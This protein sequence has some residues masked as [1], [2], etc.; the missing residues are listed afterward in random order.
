M[1]SHRDR[2]N[3]KKR[4][5]IRL[6]VSNSNNKRRV[7]FDNDSGIDKKLNIISYNVKNKSEIVVGNDQE[8]M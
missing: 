7:D 1:Q 2:K 6:S 3:V 8:I 4:T 5:Q